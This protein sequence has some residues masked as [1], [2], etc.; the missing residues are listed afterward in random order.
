MKIRNKE[1][2]F[3]GEYI[4]NKGNKVMFDES[5]VKTDCVWIDCRFFDVY[6]KE[7]E[8]KKYTLKIA[9]LPKTYKYEMEE[10]DMENNV[11]IPEPIATKVSILD[12]EPTVK[13]ETSEFYKAIRNIVTCENDDEIVVACS[14]IEGNVLVPVG[15]ESINNVVFT[16]CIDI[17]GRN[18]SDYEGK[19]IT[20]VGNSQKIVT[21]CG[22][23][24]HDSD[25]S[26]IS[27]KLNTQNEDELVFNK[28]DM[29][30]IGV[31][32]DEY[33]FEHK[34]GTKQKL[35]AKH[36]Q[37]IRIAMIQDLSV[38]P[39]D[40]TIKHKIR[41]SKKTTKGITDKL[42]DNTFDWIKCI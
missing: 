40:M 3:Y 11:L 25:Y 36:V 27:V 18:M 30:M 32:D 15:E 17:T 33:Y 16:K 35:F 12:M 1:K 10:I 2:G 34:N 19:H 7:T 38:F 23:I 42:I 39:S 20:T 6:T 22:N 14:T 28:K 5:F 37:G 8:N 21:F 24:K 31:K 26:K 29:M 9:E 13:I 41:I 4:T